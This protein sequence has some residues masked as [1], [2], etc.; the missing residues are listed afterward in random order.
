MARKKIIINGEHAA[1]KIDVSLTPSLIRFLDAI[2][3]IHNTS[4]TDIAR[5][6]MV[7]FIDEYRKQ[8]GTHA[9]IKQIESE[10]SD[11]QIKKLAQKSE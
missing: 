11:K 7:D 10:V 5:N 4:R 8:H 6:L 3:L 2:A 9:I 1:E